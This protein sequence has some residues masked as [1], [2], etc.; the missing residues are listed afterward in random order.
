MTY[1]PLDDNPPDDK[2]YICGKS[3]YVNPPDG[4][5]DFEGFCSNDCFIELY[6][7]ITANKKRIG[8]TTRDLYTKAI[9]ERA[10]KN[11]DK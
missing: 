1:N 11:K 3:I 6:K 9:I 4:T 8:K 2:C 5:W 10:L 7:K